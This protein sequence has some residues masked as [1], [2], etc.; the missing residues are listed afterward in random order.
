MRVLYFL[1]WLL[2][3]V[4]VASTPL[5]ANHQETSKPSL[6]LTVTTVHQ[7]D[8]PFWAENLAIRKNGQ[9]LVTRLDT[10]EV[11]QVDPTSS[12]PPITITTWNT[13]AYKGALGITETCDDIFYV[14]VAA[15]VDAD[16]NKLS[17]T[18]SVFKIDMNTFSATSEGVVESNA[19]VT[20]VTDILEAQF[21]D[22]ATTLDDFHIL[23]A[24]PRDGWVYKINVET[25]A[26][27]IAINDPKMKFPPGAD[28][29]LGVNG[30]KIRGSFLY[31]TNTANSTLSKIRINS[32]GFPIGS[33]S[34][35]TPVGGPDDFVFKSDGTTWIMRNTDEEL[36]Y[37]PAGSSTPILV[38]GSETSTILA[39]DTAGQFG[40]LEGDR[41]KLYL[42]TNGGKFAQ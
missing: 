33:S 38:A 9:I 8:F 4:S 42:T 13:T 20:K 41:N 37:I 26:Y 29:Q 12:V 30:I 21:I 40:R 3:A 10:P 6:P 19:T 17:G 24:D 11:L 34:I 25:G 7:F 31:W 18:C 16:F 32:S 35:V 1:S 15:P 27:T 28:L 5:N 2:A 39:G 23:A 14:L 36:S 22:G